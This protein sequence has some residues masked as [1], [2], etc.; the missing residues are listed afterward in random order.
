MGRRHDDTSRRL[1][2]QTLFSWP[3]VAGRPRCTPTREL[4]H[5]GRRLGLRPMGHAGAEPDATCLCRAG[6]F[7]GGAHQRV[8]QPAL[9]RVLLMTAVPE[10]A[11]LDAR[12]LE[13]ECAG[14]QL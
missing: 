11:D 7:S 10:Q 9:R 5:D 6:D 1:Q 3:M 14:R 8:A 4:N 13:G 12:Q 2:I